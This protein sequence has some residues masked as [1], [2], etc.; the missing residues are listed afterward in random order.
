MLSLQEL[1][2]RREEGGLQIV[3]DKRNQIGRVSDL[4]YQVLSQSGNGS[5]L[6]SSVENRWVCECS[7][8]RNRELAN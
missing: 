8:G 4:S 2:K 1:E 6:V 3:K 7:E 5:Y